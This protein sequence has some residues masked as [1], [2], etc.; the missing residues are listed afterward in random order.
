MLFDF[1]KD[2]ILLKKKRIPKKIRAQK[3]K[4]IIDSL[5]C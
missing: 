3:K 4:H 5:L 2:L 1:I